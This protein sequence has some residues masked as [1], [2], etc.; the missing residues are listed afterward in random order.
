M[1]KSVKARITWLTPDQ[2]GR[3]TLPSGLRYSTVARFESQ[4]AEWENDAWS[5]VVEFTEAPRFMPSHL[6]QVKFLVPEGPAE[7]LTSGNGFDLLEGSRV[8]ARGV[9]Q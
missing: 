6:A 9:I 8:V 7:L 2:G 1:S 3:S 4:G 5:L